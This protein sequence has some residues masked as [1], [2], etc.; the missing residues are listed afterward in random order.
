MHC[1]VI[2]F[3]ACLGC[4][5]ENLEPMSETTHAFF[6]T[7]KGKQVAC[8]TL[9]NSV[10]VSW[11]VAHVSTMWSSHFIL[12]YL[13]QR[14]INVCPK[15][16]AQMFIAMLFVIGKNGNS[17]KVH[18]RW[19]NTEIVLNPYNGILLTI[20]RN[21]LFRHQHGWHSEQLCWVNEA[22]PKRAHSVR[23]CKRTYSDIKQVSGAWVCGGQEG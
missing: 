12:R 10:A 15:I 18:Q 17:P 21:K 3:L 23:K 2:A 9:K 14:K 1:C 5:H 6:T 13:P 8:V 4:S 7:K 16:Y 19:M 20:K 11:K 22:R